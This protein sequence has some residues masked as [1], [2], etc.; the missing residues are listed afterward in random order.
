MT[1]KSFNQRS[2]V[3][4]PELECSALRADDDALRIGREGHSRNTESPRAREIR[5][6]KTTNS[7]AGHRVPNA[8]RAI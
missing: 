3:G 4:V 7:G 5:Q 1:S 6:R 8:D 2:G